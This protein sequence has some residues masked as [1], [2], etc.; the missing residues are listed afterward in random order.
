MHLIA[1]GVGGVG[2]GLRPPA[3]GDELWSGGT[4]GWACVDGVE[5]GV[6]VE[7][8]VLEEPHAAISSKEPNANHR[9]MGSGTLT[10]GGLK[11]HP[12]NL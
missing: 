11:S 4:L 2:C 3:P 8:V 1:G 10:P 6:T 9:F 5:F 12:Y 7:A